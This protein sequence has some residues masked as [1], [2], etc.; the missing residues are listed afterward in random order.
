MY[1]RWK[2]NPNP[3][4]TREIIQGSKL[5]LIT[6]VTQLGRITW[7]YLAGEA[8]QITPQKIQLRNISY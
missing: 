6:D 4:N 2:T 7:G 1:L 3:L 8:R 5:R